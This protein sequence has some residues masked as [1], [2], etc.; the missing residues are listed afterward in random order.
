MRAEVDELRAAGHVVEPIFP[1]PGG[2]FGWPGFVARVRA[3]PW[4]AIDAVRFV[5][6]ASSRLHGFDRVVA[7]WAVPSAFPAAVGAF[8]FGAR[9]AD[10][11]AF[12]L[13]V[14]SH[15]GDVRLLAGMLRAVRRAIVSR[16]A[17]RARTWRFVS[18]S[19]LEELLGSLD[20][21]TRSSVE[22]VARVAPCAIEIPD[23]RGAARAR[24]ASIDGPLLV[25]AGRLVA[26]KRFDRVIDHA[27]LSGPITLVV[28]GDGPERQRLES[29]ARALG[30]R[31][32]FTGLLP[33]P[34]ALAWIAA[35]DELVHA[36]RAEGLST[37]IREAEALGTPVRTIS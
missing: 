18:A 27:R 30:V 10:T 20:A 8:P 31:A 37:V 26:S 33:R 11:G 1:E 24:R 36:S 21:A 6:R 29:L 9:S 12:E 13:E 34:E 2:A 23:V 5:A 35:A 28:V 22:R 19:L 15:G 7:H 16:V 4:R 25:A 32:I 14:V 17:A 3:Q